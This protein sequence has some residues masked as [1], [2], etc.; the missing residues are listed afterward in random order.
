MQDVISSG[1]ISRVAV[2]FLELIYQ[3]IF[4]K[5]I[6]FGYTYQRKGSEEGKA[7]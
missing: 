2:P 3:Q 4:A 1:V 5:E 6:Y 7:R